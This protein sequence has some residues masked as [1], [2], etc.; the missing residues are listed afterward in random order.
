[1]SDMPMQPRP[2]RNTSGPV[3][4][5]LVVGLMVTF[6]LLRGPFGVAAGGKMRAHAAGFGHV[7]L[8]DAPCLAPARPP[9]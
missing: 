8:S 7:V 9:R 3:A 5:S 6:V 1:M 4:P 2:R